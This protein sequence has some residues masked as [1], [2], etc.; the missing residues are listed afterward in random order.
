MTKNFIKKTKDLG[1]QPLQGSWFCA[2]KEPCIH[3]LLLSCCSCGMPLYFSL[4]KMILKDFSHSLSVMCLFL[5]AASWL[6]HKTGSNSI[7]SDC[8]LTFSGLCLKESP[9]FH[10]NIE[11]IIEWFGVEST[12]KGYLVPSPHPWVVLDQQWTHWLIV[13]QGLPTLAAVH[14][15]PTFYQ[16]EPWWFSLVSKPGPGFSRKG[17]PQFSLSPAVQQS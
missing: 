16:A 12:I 2:W 8:F 11:E 4:Y 9:I 14:L 13:P 1:F 3:T 17:V 7:L 5:W 10:S 6:H 15:N